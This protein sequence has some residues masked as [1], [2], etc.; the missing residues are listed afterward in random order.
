MCAQG[1]QVCHEV[2]WRILYRNFNK[3]QPSV[4]YCHE[5]RA[6]VMGQCRVIKD[7]VRSAAP[8]GMRRARPADVVR[9][10]RRRRCRDG[11]PTARAH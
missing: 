8:L 9:A 11:H 1:L 2:L 4:E 3:I 10:G 5:N 7:G 6:I